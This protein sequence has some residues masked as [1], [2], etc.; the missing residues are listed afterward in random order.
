[1]SNVQTEAYTD[2]K[3]GKFKPGNPGRPRG[4]TEKTKMW[5]RL[6]E[7]ITQEGAERYMN[8]LQ[9]MDDQEF[10]KRFEM[11]LEYFK[12]KQSRIEA[13]VESTHTNI[14]IQA[15]TPKRAIGEG[16]QMIQLPVQEAEVI[17]VESSSETDS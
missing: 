16:H 10:I 4:A 12:P 14:T 2:S 13:K 5:A 15:P 9:G 6:G 1:M 7:Y 8:I 3:T 17:P 11:I